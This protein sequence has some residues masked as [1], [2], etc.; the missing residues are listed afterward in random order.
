MLGLAMP[1]GPS[2]DI[3]L[4]LRQARHA[5][6]VHSAYL[7]E[8]P[9]GTGKS[10]TALWF[11]RLLLCA[12]P[13]PDPCE[14]CRE[15]RRSALHEHEGRSRPEHP[16]LLWVEPDRGIVRIDQ[17]RALQRALDLV[18]NEGGWRAALIFGA[19]RLRVEAA[20]A[21]LHTLEEPPARTTLLLVAERAEAL[22]RTV[23]SR[24]IRLRFQPEPE[25]AVARALEAGALPAEEA[26]IAAA[27]GGGGREGAQQWAEAH[28]ESARE[29]QEWV[30]EAPS[31][32]DSEILEFAAGFRGGREES[33]E[34][35]ELFLDVHAAVARDQV[36][37][38]LER[39]EV[40]AVDR[41]LRQAERAVE[42]RRELV[43]RNLNAQML[44]ESLLLDL[45]GR[46]TRAR[47]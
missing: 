9:R 32:T 16:D 47:L 14:Q 12:E 28:L 24:V 19:E 10:E 39:E 6:R 42:A 41:W 38:A 31:R 18:P 23:R 46:P 15:C 4:E 27:L 5:G 7:F 8:G 29:F 45:K 43:R 17:I 22:P 11:A 33:R 35:V 25:E 1:Q 36:H 21:L 44:V 34:R 20:N 13:G 40:E 3:R 37:E 2:E 30:V 26:R